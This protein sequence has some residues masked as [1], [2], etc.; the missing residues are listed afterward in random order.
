MRKAI[1]FI[2]VLLLFSSLVI[3]EDCG[4][5]FSD[6]DDIRAGLS[7]DIS[8]L[9]ISADRMY[10]ACEDLEAELDDAGNNDPLDDFSY[11]LDNLENKI[12]DVESDLDRINEHIRDYKEELDDIRYDM[13]SVC[14]NVYVEY[15]DDLSSIKRD[16][17]DVKSEW[18]TVYES[19]DEIKSFASHPENY[20][21]SDAKSI[22]RGLTKD[23]DDFYDE[24]ESMSEQ[25]STIFSG[26]CFSES[27]CLTM[28][29]STIELEQSKWEN[30]CNNRINSINISCG[31]CNCSS[32]ECEQLLDKEEKE[33]IECRGE[34][35]ETK[36]M[37]ESLSTSIN[38]CDDVKSQV[39]ALENTNKKLN[40]ENIRLTGIIAGLNNS[41]SECETIECQD[42]GP[43]FWISLGLGILLILG[44]IFSM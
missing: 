38:T 36:S 6:A 28:A 25:N 17:A 22:V 43:W 1:L 32:T 37:Y 42:C 44:W 8:I 26:E 3:A 31:E 39:D 20:I 9:Y 5:L 34:L 41:V 29:E 35:R 33:H 15:D 18:N 27:D 40:N 24:V 14:Y 23:I 19:V 2:S 10:G 21:V 4:K 7:D 13:T 12:D 30:D 16:F 11:E